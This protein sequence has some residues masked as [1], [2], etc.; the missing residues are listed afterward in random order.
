[1]KLK[2]AR[3]EAGYSQVGFA[4]AACLNQFDYNK[5]ERGRFLPTV[6]DLRKI[7]LTLRRDPLELYEAEELDLAGCLKNA[8]GVR[9]PDT[10]KQR[11]KLTF[12][13]PDEIASAA[14]ADL[15]TVLGFAS[16]NAAFVAWYT[17]CLGEYKKRKAPRRQVGADSE[18]KANKSTY[19]VSS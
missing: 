12:R 11:H 2:E 13:L 16:G 6:G 14:P 18:A 9:K 8:P 7:C 19:S 3:T 17:G 1:M 5:I 15:W 10:H 4:R